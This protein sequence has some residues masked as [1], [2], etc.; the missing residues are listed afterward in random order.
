MTTLNKALTILAAL[1][2]SAGVA[3]AGQA[4]SF[5]KADAN[6]DGKITKS[7][8]S[9]IPGLSSKFSDADANGDGSLDAMEYRAAV[10]KSGGKDDEDKMGGNGY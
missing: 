10:S 6:H 3:V 7:E 9:K 5:S 1:G 4:P 8:A 2:I